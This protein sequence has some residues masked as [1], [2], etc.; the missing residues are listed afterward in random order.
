M[1]PAPEIVVCAG[2]DSFYERAVQRFVQAA[3]TAT[4]ARGRFAVALSGGSTPEPLFERLAEPEIRDA[5]PWE[6]TRVFWADERCVPPDHED[7]NYRLARKTLLDTVGIPPDRIHRIEAE[8][9][10]PD[11]AA[12]RYERQLHETLSV[13]PRSLPH[14]DLVLLGLG[15]D[16]HTASLFPE[17][18]AVGET[19]RLV[20]AVRASEPSMQPPIV[21]RITLTPPALNAAWDALFLVAGEAKAPA[22]A[23]TLEGPRAP[24]EW[25]A[26]LVEPVEGTVTWLLDAAAASDLSGFEQTAGEAVP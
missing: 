25:P 10:D 1:T 18:A 20:I 19:D 22:V 11:E 21:E 24:R 4:A 3:R 2:R 5:V 8:A 9:P 12:E 13:T 14:L 6:A 7:S 26:Q 17:S 15:A 23:A 16:G